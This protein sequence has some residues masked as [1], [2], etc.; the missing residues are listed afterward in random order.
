MK[1]L[2]KYDFYKREYHDYEVPDYWNV[3]TYCDDM[4]EI[5]NCAQCG[6]EIPFGESYTSRQVHTEHGFGYGVCRY[7]NWLEFIQE[8]GSLESK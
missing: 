6:K 1:T 4:A 8:R 7:C 3:K 2:R 5:I